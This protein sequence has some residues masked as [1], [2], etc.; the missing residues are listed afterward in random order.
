MYDT[1]MTIHYFKSNGEIYACASG[2]QHIDVMY[3]SHSQDYLLILDEIIID[4]DE[5]VLRNS[6]KFRVNIDTKNLEMLEQQ[7]NKYPIASQ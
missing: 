4:Y 5:F 1:V 2:E 3:G 6:D 7:V